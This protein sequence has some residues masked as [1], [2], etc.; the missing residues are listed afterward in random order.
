MSEEEK[1]EKREIAVPGEIIATG[2]NNNAIPF[3]RYKTGDVAAYTTK[4]SC[5]CRRNFPLLKKISGRT[6]DY[7]VDR[8][9]SLI[10]FIASENPS[11]K[12]CLHFGEQ[13]LKVM[14]IQKA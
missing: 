6:Q 8:N 10:T 2:F 14:S 4:E 7:F 11:M 3:I 9:N 13:N 12:F 5:P 1:K